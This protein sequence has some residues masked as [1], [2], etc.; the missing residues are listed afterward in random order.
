M[1]DGKDD[2]MMVVCFAFNVS[3]FQREYMK[4]DVLVGCDGMVVVL[5]IMYI[6]E[7]YCA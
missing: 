3:T 6:E 5:F 7:V 1:M 2:D 4:C